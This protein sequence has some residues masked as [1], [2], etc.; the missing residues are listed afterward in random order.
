[1]GNVAVGVLVVAVAGAIASWTIGAVY[2]ARA[3]A[4][5]GDDPRSPRRWFSVAMW[6][7]ATSRIAPASAGAASVVNKALVALFACV[8]LGAATVSYSTNLNRF[9]R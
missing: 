8:L 5:V 6:P 4:A 3:L 2:Y 9:P 1:M 7:F